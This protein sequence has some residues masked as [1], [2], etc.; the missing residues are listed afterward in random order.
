MVISN[1]KFKNEKKKQVQGKP[2]YI[3]L[4]FVPFTELYSPSLLFKGQTVTTL[5]EQK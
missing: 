3:Y 4:H 5:V 2:P 1:L